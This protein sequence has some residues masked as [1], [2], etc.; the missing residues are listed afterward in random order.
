M[1]DLSYSLFSEATDDP[2][3]FGFHSAELEGFSGTG[4]SVEDCLYQAKWGML[5][6]VALLRDQ[7]LP[8]P[9]ANPNPRV[10]IE[11]TSVRAA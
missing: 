10:I 11:N 6:H 7:E 1:I 5:E 2:L 8:V 4:H 3:F 9:A